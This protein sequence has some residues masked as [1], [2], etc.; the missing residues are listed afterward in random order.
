MDTSLRQT[1]KYSLLTKTTP[2]LF[3]FSLAFYSNCCSTKTKYYIWISFKI[4]KICIKI[5]LKA[6]NSEMK[7]T[8]KTTKHIVIMS[9]KLVMKKTPIQSS[10]TMPKPRIR[11][12][13]TVILMP[14]PRVFYGKKKSIIIV[15]H[16]H[17]F[18]LSD[19]P[20]VCL[21]RYSSKNSIFVCERIK[22]PKIFKSIS[23]QRRVLF[24]INLSAK[25]T[26]F[27]AK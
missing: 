22:T 24:H 6:V 4:L 14:K 26:L 10:E 7:T 27:A 19:W 12:K 5:K 2:L 16:L 3:C 23:V 18:C 20:S 21:I 11:K 9:C 1:N 13:H 17:F 15:K 8:T 25:Q